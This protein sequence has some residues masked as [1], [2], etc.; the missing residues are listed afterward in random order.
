MK[1]IHTIKNY[2]MVGG[3]GVMAVFSLNACDEGNSNDLNSTLQNSQKNGAFVIIEEQIDGTYKVLE[4]YPSEQTRVMLKGINGEERMLSQAEIDELI[5]QEEV[6]IDNGQSSLTNPNGG[7]LGLGGAI[8]ASAAGAIL[9]SY[10]GNKLFNNPNYQANQQRNYKSPQAYE[11][12]KN[13]F[14]NNKTGTSTSKA[15]GGKSG[16]FGGNTSTS[17]SKNST[18]GG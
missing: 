17:T 12:S 1:H 9:G 15:S 3:L 10:I 7:G 16:F 5:K 11:R 2:A 8:L 18:M 14:N 6:A 4:E 13:S